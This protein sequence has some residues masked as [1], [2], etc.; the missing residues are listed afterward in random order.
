MFKNI[1]V[2]TNNTYIQYI[3]LYFI[4]SN[5]C[6]ICYAIKIVVLSPKMI[7]F[8]MDIITKNRSD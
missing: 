5:I 1:N 7:K 4:N 3:F 8:T 6:R 2:P